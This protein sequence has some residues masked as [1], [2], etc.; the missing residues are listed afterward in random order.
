MTDQVD[1]DADS[2]ICA[3][4]FHRDRPVV[5]VYR[6]SDGFW[7]FTCGE[8]DHVKKEDVVPVCHCC[9]LAENGLTNELIDLPVDHEAR[10]D[11][12]ADQWRIS[13]APTD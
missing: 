13:P 11:G 7:T 5:F 3:H 1:H 9:A 2:L 12:V 6:E 4:A 10:W 8:T